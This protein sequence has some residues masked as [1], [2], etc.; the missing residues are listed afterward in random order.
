MNLQTESKY[1]SIESTCLVS[2]SDATRPCELVRDSNIDPT[3]TQQ[4]MTAMRMGIRQTT[5]TTNSKHSQF[6]CVYCKK[7]VPHAALPLSPRTTGSV[8]QCDAINGGL[9]VYTWK[10]RLSFL[11][12]LIAVVTTIGEPSVCLSSSQC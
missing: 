11:V 7:P 4:T 2:C 9:P 10:I 6:Q 1:S 5:I 8:V 3:R 12:Y